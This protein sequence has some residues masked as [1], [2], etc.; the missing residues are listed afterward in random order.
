VTAAVLFVPACA[1]PA[2]AP[3][4][5]ADVDPCTLLT[6]RARADLG[7]GAGKP[8]TI[9]GTRVCAWSGDAGLAIDVGVDDAHG[10]ADVVVGRGR[11]TAETVGRHQALRVAGNAGPDVCDVALATTVTSRVDVVVAAQP[12][13]TPCAAADRVAALVERELR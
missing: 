3:P 13:V 11:A 1:R 9:A 10:L 4:L 6:V 12:P 7:V 5:V 8:S 2:S